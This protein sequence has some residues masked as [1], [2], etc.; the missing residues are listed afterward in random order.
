MKIFAIL[1]VILIGAALLLLL[2]GML[3]AASRADAEIDELLRR[4]KRKNTE[5]RLDGQR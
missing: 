5:G 3:A 1:V 2:W 4:E